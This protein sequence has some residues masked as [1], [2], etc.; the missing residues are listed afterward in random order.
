MRRIVD[1]IILSV[2]IMTALVVVSLTALFV[3]YLLLLAGAAWL[4]R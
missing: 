2:V 1:F 3:L 4:P